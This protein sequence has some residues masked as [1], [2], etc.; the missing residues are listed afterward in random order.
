MKTYNNIFDKIISLDNLFS[1]WDEFKKGKQK[2]LDVMKFELN[3]EQNI[4]QLHRELKQGTYKHSPYSSFFINDPKRR[5][6]HKA[7]VR[8]RV[9]HHAV[10]FILNPIFELTFIS[11]SFSCRIEK[12]TH[13]GVK[14]FTNIL[15]KV[16]SNDNKPCFVLKCDIKKF[17]DSV[18]HNILIRILEKKIRDDDARWLLGEIIESFTSSFSTSSQRRGLPIGNLTS[19]MFANVYLNN[20]DQFVKQRLKI[21][22]YAR[23][24]DD[25]VIAADNRAYLQK[26]LPEIKYFLL[27]NLALEL[28]LDKTSIRKFNQ[29]IDFLGYVIFPKYLLIRSKTKRRILRKLRQRIIEYKNGKINKS[30]LSQSL[31]SYLGVLSHADTYEFSNNLKNQFWFWLTK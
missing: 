21:K 12:G 18:D 2:K 25:F 1:A 8:D 7:S 4:F 20:F 24:T 6:I 23:Y 16:S 29:G 3:L 31:Q 28:H 17:F 5:H 19:Q 9:L 10:F 30:T 11:N 22:Y 14:V 27:N 15:Q 26:I 13:K